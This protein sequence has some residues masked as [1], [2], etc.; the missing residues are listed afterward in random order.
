MDAPVADEPVN[1]SGVSRAA[2]HID[3]DGASHIFRLRGWQW[4]GGPD[5]VY[6]SGMEH[7]LDV[8]GAYGIR[9]TFFVIAEDLD[10]PRKAEWLQEV[11]R[12][13]HEVA[14]HSLTHAPLAGLSR[15]SKRR[16]IDGSR[17]RI[18]AALDATPDGFR[19]PYFSI[20]GESLDLLAESGYAWDSSVL[21]GRVV[22]GLPAAASSD[23]SPWRPRPDMDL[24]ELP[25]PPYRP[26]PLPFHPSYGLVLGFRYFNNGL[27]RYHRRGG[28][29]VLL[30][31][32]IDFADP[33]PPAML[34]GWRQRLFTLSYLAGTTK[35]DACRRMLEAVRARYEIVDTAALL[36]AARSGAQGN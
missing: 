24:F 8:F 18:A 17:E 15:D 13:G 3:L 12:R 27:A 36:A 33:L 4:P 11:V 32:L 29:L 19:A 34:K 14:S 35:R 2:V 1:S 10:D 9:A 16:E 6:G 23:G 26:L 7:A 31:H 28:P 30:F 5:P 21:P 25:L 22:P 20:D